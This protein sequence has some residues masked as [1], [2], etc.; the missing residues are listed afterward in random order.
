MSR[1]TKHSQRKPVD[2]VFIIQFSS[3]PLTTAFHSPGLE[4]PVQHPVLDG[5]GHMSRTDPL[6]VL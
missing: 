5:F 1:K 6:F 2:T 4:I 3:V